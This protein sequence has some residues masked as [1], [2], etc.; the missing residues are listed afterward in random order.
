M[1]LTDAKAIRSCAELMNSSPAILAY[2]YDYRVVRS[3]IAGSLFSFTMRHHPIVFSMGNSVPCIAVSAGDYYRHKN[4]G[5]L[6]LFG[7]EDCLLQGESVF[8]PGA[9]AMIERVIRD[10]KVLSERISKALAEFRKLE[11][12]FYP[13]LTA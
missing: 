11:D 10:R 7:M 4:S 6:R 12:N 5:A 13:T 1:D 3:A 2:D 9:E 8:G